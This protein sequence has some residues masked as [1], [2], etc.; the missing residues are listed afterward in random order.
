MKRHIKTHGSVSHATGKY[1]FYWSKENAVFTHLWLDTPWIEKHEFFCTNFPGWGSSNGEFELNPPRYSWDISLQSSSN[2]L[3]I[4]FLLFTRWNRYNS[5][6][7]LWIALRTIAIWILKKDPP[8]NSRDMKQNPTLVRIAWSIFANWKIKSFCHYPVGPTLRQ[9]CH[10]GW[11]HKIRDH[12]IEKKSPWN[13]VCLHKLGHNNN[14][15]INC[16]AWWHPT[17]VNNKSFTVRKLLQFSWIFSKP[18]KFS[19]LN[20]CSTESWHHEIFK[21]IFH[22]HDEESRWLL[23]RIRK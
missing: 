20:F 18:W 5:C 17:T 11:N 2:G 16:L 8:R 14:L 6:M 4:S 19:L 10:L 23:P 12:Y 21:E 3:C 1:A 22:N 7:L 15:H 9:S 13:A